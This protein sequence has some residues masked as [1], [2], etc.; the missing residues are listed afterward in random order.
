MKI[1]NLIFH[2]FDNRWRIAQVNWFICCG[3]FVSINEQKIIKK[4]KLTKSVRPSNV[5]TLYEYI[6]ILIFGIILIA[7][8]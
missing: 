8:I 6:F 1:T 4:K 5:R 7:R 3:S 2:F